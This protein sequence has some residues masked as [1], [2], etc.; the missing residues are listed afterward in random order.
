M[1]GILK[2][3]SQTGIPGRLRI[4][5]NG[6]RQNPGWKIAIEER[7]RKFSGIRSVEAS[8]VTGRVLVLFDESAMPLHRIRHIME[9]LQQDLTDQ[10]FPLNQLSDA[11]AEAAST[12]EVL[13]EAGTYD[14]WHARSVDSTIQLLQTNPGGLSLNEVNE[15][16]A[17]HGPNELQEALR[18]GWLRLFFRQ[19][20]NFMTGTLLVSAVVALFLGRV[21]DAASILGILLINA[22]L[23]T[24]QEKKADDEAQALR[25]LA[26]PAARVIRDGQEMTVPARALVPGDIIVLEPGNQ[27]P[28]DARVID[29]WNLEVDESSLTGESV[30]IAKKPG[31]CES[32][33]PLADR[34]NMLFMGS[35]VTRGRA[36]AVVVATGM[37]TELGRLFSL[38]RNQPDESTPLQKRLNVLGQ[39]LVFGSLAVSLLVMAT[40][41]LRGI[42][43][44][45]MLMTGVSL[46]TSAIPE[47]LPIMITIAL[48]VGMRRMVGKNALVRKLSALETLGRATVIC[49]DKTGTLT[50]N[51]M[52]V[53][54][55][56]STKRSWEVT[57]NGFSPIGTFNENGV[58]TN[59]KN[60]PDLKWILTAATLCNDTKLLHNKTEK[61]ET[62][63]RR[64]NAVLPETGW[65]INGDPTEGALLAAAAKAGIFPEDCR[66]LWERIK[67]T[68]FDSE[69]RR[70]SVVCRNRDNECF[71][72]VK[73]AI[74]EILK[75]CDRVMI[76]GAA[77][78]LRPSHKTGI[79]ARNDEFASRALRVLAVAYR[80]LA[81]DYDP[82]THDPETDENNLIFAG[83][84]GMIDPPRDRVKESIAICKNAGIKVV[85]ITGDHPKTAAA[86]A[87]EL[88]LFSGG[89]RV[90]TGAEL[91]RLSDEQLRAIVPGIDVFARVSPSHKL[92]IVQ[93]YKKR[94]EIVAM[95]G[96]GVNDSP[97][98]KQADVGIAMGISGVEVTKQASSMIITDDNFV[99]ICK[100]VQEGRTVLGNIRKAIGYLLS[101]NLGEVIYATLA[102]LAGMP[103]PLVPVQ[104]LLINLFT[105]ALPSIALAMGNPKQ[106]RP[107]LAV[108]NTRDVTDG[109]LIAEI[110]S[111]G[112]IIGLSTMAAFSG[113][114]ALTG[115]VVL[116]RTIAFMTVCG[117]ELMQAVD[118]WKND[119]SKPVREDLLHDR[120]MLGTLLISWAGLLSV[121]YLPPLQNLFQTVPLSLLHWMVILCICYSIS[122]LNR[123]LVRAVDS[124]IR[125]LRS[126]RA[127][128]EKN[129]I[130]VKPQFVV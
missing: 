31:L 82:E 1:F 28:A 121:V 129:G 81:G 106:E 59:V 80:P 130:Q 93:A 14:Q 118:W 67:E 29:C 26:S 108:R 51:E 39:Y 69:S 70:M 125:K 44:A 45:D 122:L 57:G 105:D 126:K 47:G 7:I 6:L 43:P 46:A 86:I 8:T 11:A 76:D 112:V 88:N 87:R 91:D 19:F 115:N 128:K 71:V 35:H 100:G 3:L 58:G 94:G 109:S 4:Q 38:I 104:I 127:K 12:A 75:L 25:K 21:M 110:I 15:R 48:A 37:N 61:W 63:L 78:P 83:L 50:K 114:L 2:S 68:P 102:I 97:A 120:F 116:A 60:E 72:F 99:T 36:R 56:A 42:P 124:F 111:R 41:L 123:P 90:I 92:R 27:I 66:K 10:T 98:V 33:T 103:L 107:T 40:G 9:D 65:T 30:P 13:R 54:A 73:G 74:E 32:G 49:T 53:R 34:T 101:G 84:F 117:S 18:P 16:F 20:A 119:D 5:V 95:T 55:I 23:G 62:I 113:T 79:L 52:T 89:G 64:Q 85:M 22:G 96:D 17:R 24:F 77:V